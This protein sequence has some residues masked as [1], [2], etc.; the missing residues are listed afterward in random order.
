MIRLIRRV[1]RRRFDCALEIRGCQVICIG[2]SRFTPHPSPFCFQPQSLPCMPPC[3]WCQDGFSQRDV[4]QVTQRGD[5]RE[6]LPW[7]GSDPYPKV[8]HDSPQGTC[9]TRFSMLTGSITFPCLVPFGAKNANCP[10][11]AISELILSIWLP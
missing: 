2:S 5:D 11:S 3:F 9:Y 6:R 10:A 7:G 4:W 1:S 8:T